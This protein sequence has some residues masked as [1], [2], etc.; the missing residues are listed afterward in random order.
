MLRCRCVYF[1]LTT[2]AVF[3]ALYTNGVAQK[4]IA[5]GQS[6]TAV[7]ADMLD[8]CYVVEEDR[9]TKL[10]SL[11]NPTG[12]FRSSNGHVES[13]DAV[14]PFKILLFQKDFY[15]ITIIDN[16]F[17]Q[18]GESL[19]L[20]DLGSNLPVFAC[21]NP[22]GGFWIFDGVEEK[23]LFFRNGNDIS[24]TS[25]DLNP[26][27]GNNRPT[28][29]ACSGGLLF[30]GIENKGVAVF[31][32]FGGFKHL[33]PLP[34]CAKNFVVNYG[35][36]FFADNSG[37]ICVV[38]ATVLGDKQMCFKKGFEY[39]GFAI[40]KKY[41]FFVSENSVFTIPLPDEYRN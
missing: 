13:V 4:R 30:L 39:Q 33:I 16:T 20:P 12:R 35:K 23:L 38:S 8:N 32:K 18:I 14:D 40:G 37:D 27:L 31:D 36:I 17:S 41:L 15:R 7:F 6:V 26:L 3:C 10:D 2:V 5:V 9:V 29:L 19:Y 22:E 1:V 21:N 34:E 11:L 25:A 28:R 24:Y